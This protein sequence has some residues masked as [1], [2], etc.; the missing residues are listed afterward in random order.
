M[1]SVAPNNVAWFASKTKFLYDKPHPAIALRA[2]AYNIEI[3]SQNDQLQEAKTAIYTGFTSIKSGFG[4]MTTTIFTQAMAQQ[5][6]SKLKQLP[7]LP[8]TEIQLNKKQ[9]IEQ[10]SDG[11][12]AA[13]EQGYSLEQI[14][15][16]LRNENADISLSALKRYLP[17]DILPT[18][19]K[20]KPRSTKKPAKAQ[21]LAVVEKPD[22]QEPEQTTAQDS[23]P[24]V[25][26]SAQPE[27]H[28]FSVRS[29]P[30]DAEKY[31]HRFTPP[32][33]PDSF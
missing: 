32:P 12:K 13:R 1:R 17:K 22:A 29:A 33:E 21:P 10:M 9:L 24:A 28:D 14:A 31:P 5:L 15:E 23:T 25:Q 6:N 7:A 11:I 2:S 3:R 27:A 18:A 19:T 26:D 30:S 4:T 8:P 16:V 20:R